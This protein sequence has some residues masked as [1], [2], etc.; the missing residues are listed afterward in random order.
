MKGVL[1]ESGDL[2]KVE[3]S[4]HECIRSLERLQCLNWS[5]IIGV[6]IVCSEITLK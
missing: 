2:K 1:K 4:A 3:Q 6:A 5:F